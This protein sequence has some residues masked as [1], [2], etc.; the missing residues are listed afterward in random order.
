MTKTTCTYFIRSCTDDNCSED[1][2]RVSN[3]FSLCDPENQGKVYESGFLEFY[4][5]ASRDK[6]DVVRQNLYSHGYRNDL[7]RQPE[8]GSEDNILQIRPSKEQMPRYKISNT[9]EWFSVFFNLLSLGNEVSNASWQFIKIL[10]TSP[11]LY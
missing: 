8:D 1:D 3:L 9:D 4:R 11:S 2:K 6:E 10:A 5:Q 7:R